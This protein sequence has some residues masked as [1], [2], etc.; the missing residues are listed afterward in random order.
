MC[1]PESGSGDGNESGGEIGKSSEVQNCTGCGK[2]SMLGDID[3][4][5]M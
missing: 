5:D 4:G 2:S 1:P 3:E